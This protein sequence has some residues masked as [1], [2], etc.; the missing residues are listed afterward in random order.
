MTDVFFSYSSRDRERVRPIRDALVAEG[1]DVFWDQEVPPGRNWDEWIRQYLDTARC[2]IVFWSEHSVRSGNVV[3]EATIAKDAQRL[4][5]VLLDL[6]GTGDFPMGHFTTQ[7]VMMLDGVDNAGSLRRLI[8]EVEAKATRRWMRRRLATLEGQVKSLT[9]IREQVE[10]HEG[11]L[12]RRV[13]ELEGQVEVA[14]RDKAR[15]QTALTIAEEKAVGFET[16]A[17]EVEAEAAHAAAVRATSAVLQQ[18]F[19]ELGAQSRELATLLT[20]L[21]TQNQSLQKENEGLVEEIE[22]HKTLLNSTR[23]GSNQKLSSLYWPEGFLIAGLL[24]CVVGYVDANFPASIIL[25]K[26][27][28]ASEAAF[29]MSIGSIIVYIALCVFCLSFVSTLS[30]GVYRKNNF[31]VRFAISMLLVP[32]GLTHIYVYLWRKMTGFYPVDLYWL[33]VPGSLLGLGTV[34]ITRRYRSLIYAPKTGRWMGG[35]NDSGHRRKGL[36]LFDK[37]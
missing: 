32:F 10:D 28:S 25:L 1:F 34:I 3:H 6:I 27:S 18:R 33:L 8:E 35:F 5:P 9:A 4:I 26:P 13:A 31:A 22:K 14:R 23:S 12:Q 37:R 11:Q 16:R 2:S 29:T 36:S 15:M 20:V 21:E 19:D 30:F 24:V 7:G 17:S